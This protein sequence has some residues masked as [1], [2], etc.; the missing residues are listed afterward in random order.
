MKSNALSPKL[1]RCMGPYVLCNTMT[2]LVCDQARLSTCIRGIDRDQH[3]LDHTYDS[4]SDAECEPGQRGSLRES[5]PNTR[6]HC[7]LLKLCIYHS[8]LWGIFDGEVT[9]L[10]TSCVRLAM[11]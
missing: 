4:V 9:H 5:T 6:R 10:H 11:H 1:G 3:A 2:Y 7:P 8:S